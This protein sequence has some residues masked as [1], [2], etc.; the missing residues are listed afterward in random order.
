MSNNSSAFDAPQEYK[1][2][3]ILILGNA[4][5]GKTTL[6]KRVCNLN[7]IEEL[8]K[9]K[10]VRRALTFAS[11]PGFIFHVSP[12]I[13]T[14]DDTELKKVEQF[15]DECAN[16]TDVNDQLHAIWYNLIFCLPVYCLCTPL[17]SV[18][19]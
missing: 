16:A 17:G 14:G 1:H 9:K 6:L 5:A 15:I 2:F 3:R 8:D 4:G 7:T 12:G 11:K 13:E 19:D 10:D 18:Y